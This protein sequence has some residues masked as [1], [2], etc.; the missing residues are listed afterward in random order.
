M[1]EEDTLENAV[2]GFKE[3]LDFLMINRFIE[4]NPEMAKDIYK[5][6]KPYLDLEAKWEFQCTSEVVPF[7]GSPIGK[8]TYANII[9]P[10]INAES[11]LA[12]TMRE[13]PMFQRVYIPN[14]GDDIFLPSYPYGEGEYTKEDGTTIVDFI[15]NCVPLRGSSHNFL[16]Y[17]CCDTHFEQSF[18]EA[19]SKN[20]DGQWEMVPSKD[21]SFDTTERDEDGELWAIDPSGYI[22]RYYQSHK[23]LKELDKETFEYLMTV[24]K[25]DPLQFKMDMLREKIGNKLGKTDQYS[26]EEAKTHIDTAE[27]VMQMKHPKRGG[28]GE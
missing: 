13:D 6:I 5:E 25:T 12:N 22:L 19:F 3:N 11:S 1:S 17:E 24:S 15:S 4:K 10:L 26:Q 21:F 20:K 2:L 28:M 16:I 8:Y 27:Q 7:I 23:K 18:I 14:K 9:I